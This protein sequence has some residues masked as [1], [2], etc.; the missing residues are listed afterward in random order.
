[1]NPEAERMLKA[2]RKPPLE[3]LL[4]LLSGVILVGMGIYFIFVRPPLL[5]EDLR[6]IGSYQVELQM[7]YPQMSV[8]LSFV[9]RVLGG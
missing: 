8:W 1:M 4:L 3:S 5:P 2:V 9:F 6:F 7:A